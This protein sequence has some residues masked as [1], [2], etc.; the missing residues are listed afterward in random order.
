MTYREEYA[1]IWH[2]F[3]KFPYFWGEKTMKTYTINKMAAKIRAVNTANEQGK[4]LYKQIVEKITPFIGTKILK[5]DD[6]LIKKIAQEI[7]TPYNNDLLIYQNSSKYTLSYVVQSNCRDGGEYESHEAIVY[8]GNIR[9]GI[10]LELLEPFN[11]RS[12]FSTQEIIEVM[13]EIK[14][15]EEKLSQAK[16]KIYPF[17]A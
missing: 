2:Q 1:T 14:N 17:V 6:K 10:L 5:A 4:L 9:D 12:D 11:E 3:S 16:N 13:S 15:L 7:K 8:I